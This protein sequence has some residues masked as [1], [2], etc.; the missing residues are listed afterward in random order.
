MREGKGLSLWRAAAD[1]TELGQAH[2]TQRVLA[3]IYQA[4][5]RA[6][7]RGGIKTD[8]QKQN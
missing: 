8:K 5:E 1:T 7:K 3:T 6:A 2:T 4:L